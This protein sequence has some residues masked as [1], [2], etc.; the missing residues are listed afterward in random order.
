MRPGHASRLAKE[1]R[2]DRYCRYC[3]WTLKGREGQ[4]IG[5]CGKHGAAGDPPG[6]HNPAYGNN[7]ALA[8]A[9]EPRKR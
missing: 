2:P 5:P 8:Q 9:Q 6:A 7:L 1:K 4:Y 3:L